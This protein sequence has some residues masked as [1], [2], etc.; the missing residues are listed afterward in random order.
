[1]Y[2]GANKIGIEQEASTD[3]LKSPVENNT[4]SP[5]FKFVATA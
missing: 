3:F 2:S 1:M 5:V 4:G